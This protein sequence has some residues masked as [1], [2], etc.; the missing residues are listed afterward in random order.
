MTQSRSAIS[1]THPSL[2]SGPKAPISNFQFSILNAPRLLLFC[3]VLLLLALV[4]PPALFAATPY[5]PVH[6]DPV[7]EPWRWTVYPE[8]ADKG[9]RCLAEDNEG[10]MWFGVDDG[11]VCYDGLKWTPYTEAD[12]LLGS[13][14]QTLCVTADSSV[15]AGTELGISRYRHGT[16]SRVFPIQGDLPWPTTDLMEASDGT[17]WAGTAWGALELR[18]ENARLVTSR[19]MAAALGVLA[20][21]VQVSVVPDE[22]APV[23]S[24]AGAGDAGIGAM[25][26][27]GDVR[28]V[29][30][31]AAGGPAEAA[32]L[33]VGDRIRSKGQAWRR[34]M[35]SMRAG[36]SVSLTV[37][38]GGRPKPFEIVVSAGRVEGGV[39]HFELYDVYEGLDKALWFG[40]R[41][42]EVVR[43]T[44]DGVQS[45]GSGRWRFFGEADGYVP[46]IAPRILQSRDGVVWVVSGDPRSG[47][48]R[49]DGQRWSDSHLPGLGDNGEARSVLETSD[50]TVWVGCHWSNLFACRKGVW[51]R[52]RRR[53]APLPVGRI[54]GLLEASDGAI[55]VVGNGTGPARVDLGTTK[56]STY[57]G[58]WLHC[59]TRDGSLWFRSRD[60]VIR[61]QG[62][63]TGD[64]ESL[65]ATVWTRYGPDDGLMERPFRLLGTRAGTVWAGCGSWGGSPSGRWIG[66][67]WASP[68]GRRSARWRPATSRP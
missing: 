47:V 11:V 45:Q 39:R 66:P 60:S 52:Y 64:S 32:G 61:R 67:P 5:T 31:V 4:A 30:A 10:R 8:I 38:R 41:T 24:W 58:L 22:A 28:V 35:L 55:W 36:E 17:L 42:G 33:R 26:T 18:G 44:A 34:G 40:L 51:T 27:T 9:P 50:G 46:G 53:D 54:L 6:P 49:Y 57:Q 56:W 48:Y 25:M 43:R 62:D 59:Q 13:P 1:P 2:S 14:V 7:L 23:R 3:L 19:D 65:G 68:R 15:Y 63:G 20:P 37:Q 29:W 16:W 21:E 12:G